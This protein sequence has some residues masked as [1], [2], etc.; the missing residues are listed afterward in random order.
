VRVESVGLDPSVTGKERG[1]KKKTSLFDMRSEPQKGLE[2]KEVQ[3][4]ASP[5]ESGRREEDVPLAAQASMMLK[6]KKQIWKGLD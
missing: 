1:K 5:V 4:P 2:R 6:G 3:L